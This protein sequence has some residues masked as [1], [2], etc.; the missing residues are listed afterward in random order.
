MQN[1]YDVARD[2]ANGLKEVEEVKEYERIKEEISSNSDLVDMI[3]DFREKQLQIQ[4]RQMMGEE[5][6]QESLAD[7]QKLSSVAMANPK[8]AEYISAE[9][10]VS[11]LLQDIYKIIGEAVSL[12][13]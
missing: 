4:T 6:D 1:V 13:R 3:N 10:R 12:M 7:F 9:Y 5:L 8:V 11:I 2:L